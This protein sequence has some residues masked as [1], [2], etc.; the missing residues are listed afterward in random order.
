V[1]L[2]VIKRRNKSAKNISV[3]RSQRKSKPLLKKN[4]NSN[5]NLENWGKNKEK[6]Y[7]GD[8][9]SGDSEAEIE[10]EMEAKAL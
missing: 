8:A 2:K 1:E 3:R 5:V 7:K 9:E 4:V 10:E 6:Y